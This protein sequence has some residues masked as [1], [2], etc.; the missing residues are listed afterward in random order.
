MSLDYDPALSYSKKIR[1]HPTYRHTK[2][3]QI[4]GG[5]TVTLS[6]GSTTESVF[7]LPSSSHV[8]NHA[9]SYLKFTLNVAAGAVGQYNRLLMNGVSMIDRVMLQT[10]SGIQ[11]CDVTNVPNYT[12]MVNPYLTKLSDFVTR[13]SPSVLAADA[14]LSDNNMFN[15]SRVLAANVLNVAPD[16]TAAAGS[17][18]YSDI[19][20]YH[21]GAVEPNP[22]TGVSALFMNVLLP[23]SV[24]APDTI[25]SLDR[26]MFYGETLLLYVYWS[27]TSKI[28]FVGTD[29]AVLATGVAAPAGMTLSRLALYTAIESN[30]EIQ[31]GLMA[32]ANSEGGISMV[33]PYVYG[34]K[35]TTPPATSSSI[36]TRLSRAHGLN[37]LRVWTSIF[38]ANSTLQFTN[39]HSNA[40]NAVWVDVYDELNSQRLSDFNWSSAANELYLALRDKLEGSVI[41]NSAMFRDNQVW[42]RDWTNLK[43]V[44]FIENNTSEDGVSL[45]QEQIYTTNINKANAVNIIFTFVVTQKILNIGSAGVTLM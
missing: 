7:E 23:M 15:P 34:Y 31:N 10:K 19:S 6:A 35:T 27:Q 8:L 30:V 42:L 22:A 16:G 2:Q 44:D 38:N 25:L 41:Q 11:L 12:S 29:A 9:K 37:L 40:A 20:A 32:K 33:I 43:C 45:A 28:G 21:R 36:Q 1:S 24:I 13:D 3:Y 17:V 18:D 5:Q 14:C 26:D 39:L 4:A